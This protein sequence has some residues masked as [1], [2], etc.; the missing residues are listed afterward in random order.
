MDGKVYLTGAG[1]GAA[2]LLTLRAVRVLAQADVILVDDLVDESVLG[3]AR[4]D[5]RIVHV[6]KRGGCRST[7]QAFIERLM[8]RHARQGRIVVRLKGG[9]PFVFGRGGEEIAFLRARG[10]DVEVVP[11]ITSGIAAPASLGIPVTHR[12]LARGVTLVTGHTQDDGEPDWAALARTSTTLVV[13]MGLSRIASI[14]AGLR[15]GGLPAT[16]PVAVIERGTQA[17]QCHVTGTLADIAARV[18]AE[19][20]RAP[21]IIVVGDVVSLA[22]PESLLSA[23]NAARAA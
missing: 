21:S 20:L 10:V 4:P 15:A 14:C 17:V 9:D 3:H 7:P 2:D 16:T 13:Y 23:G 6:G 19:Q 5:A 18:A 8:A 12:G 11:G 1:P 22:H